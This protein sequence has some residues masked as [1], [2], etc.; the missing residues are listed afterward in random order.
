MK[1]QSPGPTQL[2]KA[3]RDPVAETAPAPWAVLAKESG[4]TWSRIPEA[5]HTGP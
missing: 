3:G 2:A 1:P 5:E 4:F